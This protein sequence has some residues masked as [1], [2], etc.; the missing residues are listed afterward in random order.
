VVSVSSGLGLLA[1][2]VSY[3]LGGAALA[4]PPLLA[5]PTPCPGWNLEMLLDHL[6]DSIGVLHEAIATEVS[7]LGQRRV[8]TGPG[9]TRSHA[10]AARQPP[11]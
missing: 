9:A 7:A 10:C 2:A 4:T 1:A 11:C 8:T 6:G 3:A 5:S